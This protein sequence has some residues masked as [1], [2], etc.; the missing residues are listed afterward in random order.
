MASDQQ[1]KQYL[2]YWAQLGKP[3][4]DH[5][6][7]EKLL[8]SSVIQG[9]RYSQEFEDCWEQVI[10][11]PNAYHLE[12]TSETIGELRSPSWEI[13]PCSRCAMPVPI[14]QVGIQALECPCIDLPGWPNTELPQ[15]REPISSRTSLSQIR[16][17]LRADNSQHRG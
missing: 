14:K 4:V 3:I 8:P 9:D 12:G 2:A 15:P 5:A 1:L 16:D 10:A 13:N 17:R 11:R 6:G 7:Q